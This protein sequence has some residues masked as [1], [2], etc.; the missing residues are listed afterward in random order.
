MSE[1]LLGRL[2]PLP[3][4]AVRILSEKKPSP[5]LMAH[6]ML[7][8]DVAMQLVKGLQAAYPSLLLDKDAIHFGSAIHDIGKW[9]FPNEM[10]TDGQQHLE[11]GVELLLE[12]GVVPALARFARTHAT[13]NTEPDIQLEDLIVALANNCWHGERDQ[14]LEQ[15]ILP[16]LAQVSQTELW[17]T[18]LTFDQLLEQITNAAD[19]RIAW[20]AQFVPTKTARKNRSHTQKDKIP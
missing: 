6:L 19:E 9:R 1:S 17:E 3:A 5:L 7:V 4:E 15:A 12:L 14:Q 20:Q 2:H 10:L 8:Q 13:W 16:Y 11:A 18:F